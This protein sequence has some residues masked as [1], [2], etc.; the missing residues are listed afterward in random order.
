MDN[1][2]LVEDLRKSMDNIF[3]NYLDP[4]GESTDMRDPKGPETVEYDE[5]FCRKLTIIENKGKL[6]R[7]FKGDIYLILDIAEHT[8]TGEEMVIYKAIYEDCK[9]YARPLSM[10]IEKVP[11]GKDNPTQQV[12]R[13]EPV[14]FESCKVG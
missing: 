1:K 3:D 11:E 6:V 10:F 7:H 13:F 4:K 12:Y 9:V 8:E 2:Q 5:S 14:E